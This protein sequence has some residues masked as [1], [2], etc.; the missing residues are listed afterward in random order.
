MKN[1]AAAASLRSRFMRHQTSYEQV[2]S[3]EAPIEVWPRIVAVLKVVEEEMLKA[4][5]RKGTHGDRYLRSWRGLIALL[6]VSKLIG[7]FDFSTTDILKIDIPDLDKDVVRECCEFVQDR[8]SGATR[9]SFSFVVNLC[10]EFSQIYSLSGVK[11]ISRRS[12]A[13]VITNKKSTEFIPLSPAFLN[14]VDSLLP[15]QPWRQGTH[16]EIAEKLGVV[17][18]L[19]TSAIRQLID[20]GHRFEQINGELYDGA[21]Q[22]IEPKNI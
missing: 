14:Q 19:V 9:P 12:T 6:V 8:R 16:L 21:G 20:S 10:L 3:D 13:T 22:L 4:P 15:P 7:K 17:P 1:P 11:S 18:K 5:R 2:F